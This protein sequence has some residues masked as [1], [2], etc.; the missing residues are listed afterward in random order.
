M[1]SL[2][3]LTGRILFAFIFIGA[4]PRHFSAEGIH[5]AA[6]LGVP[7][8]GIAVP[9]SGVLAIVGG[10]SVAL[11]YHT[12]WGAWALVAFLVPITFSMHAFWL[13]SDELMRH[14][15][16]AMFAKNL[17]MLGAALLLTQLGAGPWSID[18]WRR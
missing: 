14:V 11:G 16:L 1:T 18:A 15:Q 13:V 17:S 8:A 10:V 6:E 5:H 3:V 9:I 7:F 12:R 2:I 4:A